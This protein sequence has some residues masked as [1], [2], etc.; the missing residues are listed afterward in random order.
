MET[1]FWLV[2]GAVRDAYLG[3]RSKDL[4]FTVEAD[5][6]DEMVREVRR[7]AGE[8][9]LERPEYLTVRARIGLVAADFVLARRDGAYSDRRR[10]D[11]VEPGTIEDDLARRD[12]TC[13]AIAVS[14]HPSALETTRDP[15]RLMPASEGFPDGMPPAAAWVLDPHGGRRDIRA[16]ALRAVGRARDRLE[17]DPLRAVRALRFQLTRGLEPD[18]ELRL[19][20][21]GVDRD[22]WRE[23]G[24]APSTLAVSAERVREELDRCC[25]APGGFAALARLL[26][27][28]PWMRDALYSRVGFR[29]TLEPAYPVSSRG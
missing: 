22:S 14:V 10:P 8:I 6:Y 17:E 21:M 13:N 7:S 29:P 23:N 19:E 27:A 3:V 11:Q 1:R 25:R 15:L 26:D 28:T 9:F 16:R 2:G 18:D 20:L 24:R 4:D 12:F 5:G